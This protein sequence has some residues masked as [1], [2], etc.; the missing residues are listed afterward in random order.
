MS[1]GGASLLDP[2]ELKG[3]RIG[4]LLFRK[5]GYEFCLG[6]DSN[7]LHGHRDQFVTYAEKA[8]DREDYCRH[9][10]LIESHQQV[11][12][13]TDGRI[14]YVN[15]AADQLARAGASGQCCGVYFGR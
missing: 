6:A 14:A 13:L 4:Q 3:R 8:T 9:S 15:L 1:T 11:F 2:G 5:I 10:G 12:D 7:L